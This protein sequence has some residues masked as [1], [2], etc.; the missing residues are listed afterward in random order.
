[1]IQIQRATKKDAR[2][3]AL[4]GRITFNETFGHLFRNKQDLRDYCERTFSVNKIAKGIT[5]EE[6]LFW[7]ATV[8]ALPVG[9]AKLKLDM[10]SEFLTE[11]NVCQL[12]KIYVLQDFL[13]R[14]IGWKL[15]YA[16]V[17]QAKQLGFAHIWLSVL[18]SNTRAIGFYK[19]NGFKAIGKHN[20]SIGQEGFEFV[21]M[22]KRL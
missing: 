16:L 4:L 14:K 10:P 3:I 20:Y 12:Q 13:S 21:A 11:D 15:Q 7:L 9:Y 6:N 1:M 8:D 17:Q 5:K 18:H 19:Q 22:A 2:A